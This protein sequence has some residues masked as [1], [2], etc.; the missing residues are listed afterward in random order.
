M[1]NQVKTIVLLT[2]LSMLFLWMGN[3]IGGRSGMG[4]ALILSLVM[5]FGSYWFSD[6]LVLAAHRAKPINPGDPSGVYEIVQELCQKGNL[7]M[8]KVYRVPDLTP[9]A[10]ATGRNPKHA[11]VAVT[12]GI[13]Q[14]LSPRELRGVLGHEISHIKNSDI[15]VSTIVASIASAIMYLTHILQWAGM[16][17]G[18]RRDEEGRGGL[19]P[20]LMLVTIILAPLAATLVQAAISR[21][22]EFMADESG[23]DVSSDPEALASALQKISDPSLIAQI[24]K[25][26]S[27]ENNPAFSHLYIINHFSGESIMSLFSTHPPVKERVRRLM[28][29]R[30]TR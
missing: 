14:I 23:A 25:G 12:E 7:P 3:L 16:F 24:K 28:S 27:V 8:P 29:M 19:N 13:L 15:L 17:S 30:G 20:I 26:G 18:G 11:A 10:F 1:K 5:N 4:V 6:K 21:S 2:L 9:N 22:R